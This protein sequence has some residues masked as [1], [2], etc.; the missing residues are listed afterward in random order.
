MKKAY[1]LLI[2]TLLL[3]LLITCKKE[4]KP[5]HQNQQKSFESVI[6]E[7]GGFA[8]VQNSETVTDT[9]S[10]EKTEDGQRWRC[11]TKTLEAKKGAGGDGG[12]P[13]FNPNANVIYP[14]SLLQGSSLRKATPDVIAVDRAGGTISYD[15]IDGNQQSSFTVDVVKKSSITDGM[16]KII[17]SSSGVVPANFN[18]TYTNIQSRRQ[19]ALEVEADYENAFLELEGYLKLNTDKSY[20]SYLVQLNQSYYTMS[21]DIP[22]HKDQLFAA[23]VTPADL[24]RYVGPGNPAT[25]VSDVTYGRTYYMLIE[26]TASSFDMEAGIKGSFSAIA[27]SGGGSVDASYLS[28]LSN[29]KI[30]VFA[31]GGEASAT[32]RTVVD[33]STLDSLVN[34]LASAG[35]IRSGKPVSYVVRSVYDNRVV[36][37][38]LSNKYDITNCVPIGSGNTPPAATS[39][40]DGVVRDFGAIGAA[41]NMRYNRIALFNKAGN[42][43]MISQDNNILTGPYNLSDLADGGYN[44]PSVGAGGVYRSSAGTSDVYF[45]DLNGNT[46]QRMYAG[47]TFN[48]NVYS[49]GSFL[50][51]ACPFNAQ[52]IT[53]MAFINLSS[54]KPLGMIV[55]NKA[56]DEYAIYNSKSGQVGWGTAKTITDPE[57]ALNGNKAPFTAFGAVCYM[58]IGNID[59]L[60]F[61]N[62]QGTQYCMWEN[63]NGFTPAYDL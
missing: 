63:V 6:A 53:G 35:D 12:F 25:Y 54:G 28:T 48:T 20:T 13:L 27:S 36:S 44:L 60:L 29:L 34:K 16:N 17:S 14:G 45:F 43:F 46:Y 22:T 39:H 2:A 41:V 55:L 32:L 18:F 30:Q 26:S 7:G 1:T 51:G 47:N 31:Y 4:E 10:T 19:F 11:T 61:F 24:A 50:G 42:R 21:F 56:G 40:W 38:Q 57:L 15:I 59:Y 5:G 3:V 37:V 33:A 52:G 58:D 49:I 9:S 23:N 8:P 62:K